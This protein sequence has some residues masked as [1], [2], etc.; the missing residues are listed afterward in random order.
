ML[1]ILYA[2]TILAFIWVL[3]TLVLG[4]ITMGQKD[5]AARERSNTWMARRV[6]AQAVAIGLLA[7]TW[8]VK[9]RGG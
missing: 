5:E 8:Y 2:L 7:L 9:S 3:A 4:A 1:P 6:T